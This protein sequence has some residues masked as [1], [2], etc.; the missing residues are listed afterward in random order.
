[1]TIRDKLPGMTTDDGAGSLMQN[2]IVGSIYIFGGFFAFMTLLAVFSIML[3]MG[4]TDTA[5]DTVAEAD[6]NAPTDETEQAAESEV[7]D[8][9]ANVDEGEAEAETESEPAPESEPSSESQ[10]EPEAMT[11]GGVEAEAPA[12]APPAENAVEET[13][14]YDGAMSPELMEIVIGN[15][16]ID[17]DVSEHD[18]LIVA[19]YTGPSTVTEEQLA[20]DLGAIAGAY[21]AMVADGYP[22]EGLEINIYAADGTPVGYTALDAADAQAWH[23]GEMSD[24]E[25][26]LK[27]LDEN[28]VVYNV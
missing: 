4:D 1:M 18:G 13:D 10:S 21:T 28:L 17:V 23:D 14:E 16:G 22:T 6:T 19:D 20:G 8:D 9:D 12:A 15:E 24:D 11:D 27:I 2:L 3:G 7:S 26:A 25:F 5:S